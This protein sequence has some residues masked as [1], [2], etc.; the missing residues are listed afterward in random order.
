MASGGIGRGSTGRCWGRAGAGNERAFGI[1]VTFYA[2]LLVLPTPN[3]AELARVHQDP[4]RRGRSV[5]RPP[6]T[7]ANVIVPP[8]ATR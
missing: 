5:G 3:L 1:S 6:S 2:R 7:A 4:E 8:S